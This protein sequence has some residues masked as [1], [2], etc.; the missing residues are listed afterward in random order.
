[1]Q[2]YFTKA[3]NVLSNLCFPH[4]LEPCDYLRP[5]ERHEPAAMNQIPGNYI[6]IFPGLTM[7][8]SG[9]V[10]A[11]K[12]YAARPGDVVVSFWNHTGDGFFTLLAK[13]PITA[14]PG[15]QVNMEKHINYAKVGQGYIRCD[16]CWPK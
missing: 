16:V 13:I 2:R 3:K 8:R 9:Y 14:A 10:S 7:P 1:M 4:Y 12:Y 5:D 6:N 15:P 11:V